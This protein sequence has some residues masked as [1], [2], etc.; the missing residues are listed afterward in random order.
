MFL[1][2]CSSFVLIILY[3][4]SS[5]WLWM[6]FR[7]IRNIVKTLRSCSVI[8]GSYRWELNSCLKIYLLNKEIKIGACS[9]AA[10]ADKKGCSIVWS[11]LDFLGLQTCS[12]VLEISNQNLF[13]LNSFR[14]GKETFLISRSFVAEFFDEHSV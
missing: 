10:N 7:I 6:V 1:S 11:S 5:K 13:Y 9:I 12:K 2:L 4:R 3:N 14:L 8:V